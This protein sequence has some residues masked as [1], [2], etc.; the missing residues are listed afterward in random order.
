MEAVILAAGMGTRLGSLI[1]KPLTSLVD[2]KTILD[3]QIENL[4][5]RSQIKKIYLVVGYKKEIIM[6]KFPDLLF[7]YNNAYART[8]TAK[9]L[10]AALNKIEDDVMW[11]NGDV[12]FDTE[13]LDLLLQSKVSACLVDRKKCGAE[14]IKYRLN[15]DGFIQQLSKSVKKAQGEAL[16]INVIRK[17]DLKKFRNELVKVGESDYFEKAL[18]NLTMSKKL[19][20]AAIDVGPHFCREIDFE[21]DLVEVQS[22]LKN[23]E[24]L[25][26]CNR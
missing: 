6:E 20:L 18:E 5:C 17:S 24:L 14:E 16:G 15:G 25:G 3:H 11:M 12:F 4:M 19:K 1:P 26:S 10:L 2:E 7:V 9:S 22:Y 23:R 13:I 8:N 21:E